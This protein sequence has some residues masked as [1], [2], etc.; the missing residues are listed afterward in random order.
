MKRVIALLAFLTV[1]SAAWADPYLDHVRGFDFGTVTY[2]EQSSQGKGSITIA[3]NSN[4]GTASGTGH[5]GSPDLNTLGALIYL[6][7]FEQRSKTI[8]L[9]I[10]NTGTINLTTSGCGTIAISNL[11]LENNSTTYSPK[12]T[13]KTRTPRLGATL[14]LTDFQ[15]TATCTIS[16]TLSGIFGWKPSTASSYQN[17][18]VPVQIVVIPAI[19]LVH[20]SQAMLN[21]GTL[22][23]STSPQTLTV[24]PS[25]AAGSSTAVCPATADISADSFTFNNPD[26]VAFS[27]TM[28]N[29]A[30]LTNSSSGATLTVNNFTYN[31]VGG[32]TVSSGSKQFT[33]GGT[34]NIPASPSIGEYTGEYPVTVTF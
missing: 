13:G 17:V 28:P 25:G 16:G 23:A 26:P 20:D 33:V 8:N 1:Y 18:D 7:N 4:T 5:M 21:F 29:S 6:V 31:C 14:R 9:K 32:C 24:T 19:S 2:V 15:G 12:F 34:L 22:C 10:N 11:L 3:Y 30:T 27:V